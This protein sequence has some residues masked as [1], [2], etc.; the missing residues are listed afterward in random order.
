MVWTHE[1][2]SACSLILRQRPVNNTGS[3]LRISSLATHDHKWPVLRWMHHLG[4]R[5]NIFT[6]KS[7]ASAAVDWVTCTDAPCCY[8]DT[9]KT[10]YTSTIYVLFG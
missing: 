6:D 7:T 5:V 9:A 10:V 3:T 4:P 1:S 2:R 8:T